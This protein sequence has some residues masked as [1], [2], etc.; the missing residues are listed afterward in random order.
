MECDSVFNK[1]IRYIGTKLTLQVNGSQIHFLSGL[2]NVIM[3]DW[4]C[5]WC[6]WMVRIVKF[7]RLGGEC[8]FFREK[9]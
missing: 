4:F 5:S 6:S 8:S 1:L 2:V 7:L 3:I 9:L